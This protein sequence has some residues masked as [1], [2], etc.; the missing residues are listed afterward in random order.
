MC[1]ELDTRYTVFDKKKKNV[2]LVKFTLFHHIGT[3]EK[4]KNATNIKKY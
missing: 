4:F 3:I 2:Q 1:F